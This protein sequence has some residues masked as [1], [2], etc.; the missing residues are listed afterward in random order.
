MAAL[1]QLLKEGH[2]KAGRT[3]PVRVIEAGEAFEASLA[4]NRLLKGRSRRAEQVHRAAA[5]AIV[6]IENGYATWYEGD[7]LRGAC[8]ESLVGLYAA[9]RTLPCGSRVTVR[10][11][12]R[13]ITVP[14]LDRG[15]FGDT[16][17]IIDLSPQAFSALAPLGSGVI[18]VSTSRLA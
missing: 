11:G 7:G 5:R 4:E 18:Y 10:Y 15:P 16:A 3:V 14:I 12:G 2:F 6:S 17:R 1:Q 8:G 13:S 9:S